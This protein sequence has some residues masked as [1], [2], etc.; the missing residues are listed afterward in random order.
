MPCGE[1]SCKNYY[2]HFDCPIFP[3]GM[4]VG[5]EIFENFTK[6]RCNPSCPYYENN[7][8]LPVNYAEERPH[9]FGALGELILLTDE[10]VKEQK[11]KRLVKLGIIK[12]SKPNSNNKKK[13]KRKKR[14]R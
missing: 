9:R 2:P 13:K 12:P 7:G 8:E 3:E 6:Y 10:E 14:K 1:L 11:M 5:D 4:R